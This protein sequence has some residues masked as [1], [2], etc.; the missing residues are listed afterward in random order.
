MTPDPQGYSGMLPRA[1]LLTLPKPGKLQPSALGITC[2]ISR[3]LRLELC[4]STMSAEG[5]ERTH[6]RKETEFESYSHG[7]TLRFRTDLELC[8]YCE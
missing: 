6:A 7:Q 4:G 8:E 5:V 2:E 3:S 1:D